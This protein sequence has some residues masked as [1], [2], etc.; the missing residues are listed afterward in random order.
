MP[1]Y[2]PYDAAAELAYLR[3]TMR[4]NMVG[5]R[6]AEMDASVKKWYGEHMSTVKLA[7]IYERV[8]FGLSKA[9]PFDFNELDIEYEFV[10]F[11]AQMM[12]EGIYK[13]PY[14]VVYVYRND[15]Q[16]NFVLM[17]EGDVGINAV[18]VVRQQGA[19]IPDYPEVV[20]V[21][22]NVI[23]TANT[24]DGRQGW[25]LKGDFALVG[26]GQYGEDEHDIETLSRHAVVSAIAGM[27]VL[28]SKDVEVVTH[29]TPVKLNKRRAA[30]GRPEIGELR[31]VK[32]RLGAPRYAHVGDGTHA[33]PRPHM[34]RGHWRKLRGGD[35]TVVAPHYVNYR[36]MP[37]QEP[38]RANYEVL[39]K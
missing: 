25:G 26:A 31:T 24:E 3:E 22:S 35:F 2:M 39:K 12:A 27:T 7:A 21:A 18:L 4:Q 15:V 23:V 36:P 38:P 32:I 1:K 9:V 20:A 13:L 11:T 6:A 19:K 16:P 5:A 34:R 29:A 28:R 14:E 10:E 37:G 30:Q 8:A 17:T 33:S